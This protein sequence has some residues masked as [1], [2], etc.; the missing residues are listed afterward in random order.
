MLVVR[1]V[2]TREGR[3]TLASGTYSEDTQDLATL[4]AVFPTI[5]AILIHFPSGVEN[6]ANKLNKYHLMIPRAAPRITGG[7]GPNPP[8]GHWE[9]RKHT[10]AA[11]TV[12]RQTNG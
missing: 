8:K 4:A 11:L 12:S 9:N 2:T 6:E 3:Y 1:L 10:S 7:Q 5:I